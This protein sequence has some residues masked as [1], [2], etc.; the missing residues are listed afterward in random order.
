MNRVL[1][2][3][4]DDGLVTIKDQ[5]VTIGDIDELAFMADFERGYLKPLPISEFGTAS[6]NTIGA[7]SRI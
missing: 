7:E 5:K 3:L 6:W 1:R 2:R 4:A